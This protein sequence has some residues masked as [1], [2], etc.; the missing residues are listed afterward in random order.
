MALSVAFEYIP[1]KAG[2]V[3]QG[4]ILA[5][6]YEHQVDAAPI[7]LEEGVSASY[8]SVYHPRVIVVTSDCDLLRDFEYRSES[9]G[10][11]GTES[12]SNTDRDHPKLL[13]HVVLCEV[14]VREEVRG[15]FRPSALWDRIEQ[16]QDERYHHLKPASI[17]N[18]A[19]GSL[20]DLYL[21]FKKTWSISSDLLLRALADSASPV[22]R[23]A[24][25]PPIYLQDLIHR[26]FS[27]QSRIS[28]DE[29]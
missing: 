10:Q 17:G 29:E 15:R 25:I 3:Q 6:L 16:N 2:R 11:S 21:D 22:T 18:P 4:E 9:R 19:V 27:F 23:V 13:P 5:D 8:R 12:A 26:Y 24:V 28:V 20:P 7:E 1:P 14:Y